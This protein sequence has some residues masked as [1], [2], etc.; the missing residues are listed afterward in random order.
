MSSW[1]NWLNDRLPK[2]LKD[3][4]YQETGIGDLNDLKLS[5]EPGDGGRWLGF[6]DSGWYYHSGLEQYKYNDR[7]SLLFNAP[8]G[9][10][11]VQEP[12]SFRPS[13]GPVL[14]FGDGEYPY[15]EHH[16]V[17]HP[18]VPL[19]WS[20]YSGDVYVADVPSG[21][22]LVGVRNLTTIPLG[23]V[24]ST[25]SLISDR[26]YHYDRRNSKVYCRSTSG[27]PS[28][29]CDL[30]LSKPT[31]RFRELVVVSKGALRPSYR[32]IELVEAHRG[33][34]IKTYSDPVT[35]EVLPAPSGL[36]DGDWVV[37]EY[38]IKRSFVVL[39]HRTI[40][41]YTTALSGQTVEV[42]YERSVPGLI[43]S[44]CL[45]NGLE[46]NFNPLFKDYLGS[47]YLFHCPNLPPSGWWTPGRI[48]CAVDK[49]VCCFDWGESATV[50]IQVW[51]RSGTPA[52]AVSGTI[53]V[54]RFGTPVSSGTFET[55]YAGNCVLPLTAQASGTHVVV[56][57]SHAMT[58][59]ATVEFSP[60]ESIVPLGLDLGEGRVQIAL[61][62][63]ARDGRYILSVSPVR[64]DGLPTTQ[65]LAMFSDSGAVFEVKDKRQG[66]YRFPVFCALD[67]SN[68]GS[69][70]DV[71]VSSKAGGSVLARTSYI[72]SKV[73]ELPIDS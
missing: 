5:V 26:Y 31:I 33:G 65:W 10:G 8:A 70:A 71:M 25:S 37:L 6:V 53:Q 42:S 67:G 64:L 3:V 47:G 63:R 57:Q 68:P 36:R 39:D 66:G 34:L 73:L 35:G 56:V 18:A 24:D 72:A 20:Q 69:V 11:L 23:R 19:T 62:G 41:T 40:H 17:F 14:V 59:S 32:D 30:L 29:Y 46:I 9:T 49:K 12:V 1:S 22:I 13:W 44:A 2:W 60:Q 45:A 7:G 61:K 15:T 50:L 16:N 51:D 54:L 28:V 58:A 4:D 38:Y 52:P 43:P 21:S 55:D 48:T 27:A